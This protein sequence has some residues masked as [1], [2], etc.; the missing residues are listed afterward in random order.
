MEAAGDVL[1][2]PADKATPGGPE[3]VSSNRNV[4]NLRDIMGVTTQN[5]VVQQTPTMKGRPIKQVAY[6]EP[7][8]AIVIGN[9]GV[10]KTRL[11][12]FYVHK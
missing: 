7:F 11:T 2:I 9:A 1:T 3:T 4:H 6:N 8:K 10:G 12:Y 5:G